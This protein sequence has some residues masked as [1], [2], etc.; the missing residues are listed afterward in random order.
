MA[1][2]LKW[3]DSGQKI[4]DALRA[5][6][7]V[8]KDAE[9]DTDVSSN[10]GAD[11]ANA[12]GDHA[13]AV[14]LG[15]DRAGTDPANGADHAAVYRPAIG[16]ISQPSAAVN[17]LVADG[18]LKG[19]PRPRGRAPCAKNGVPKIWNDQLGKWEDDDI[20][21]KI[22][23]ASMIPSASTPEETRE[24]PKKPRG[25]PPIGSNKIPQV[26]NA[27]LGIYVD[28]KLEAGSSLKKQRKK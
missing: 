26:W 3:P 10:A 12:N 7:D 13:S 22:L 6:L 14:E 20:A 27:E 24:S 23:E 5:L 17:E 2:R 25:R 15:A 18:D 16:D 8:V 1:R 19:I 4:Q 9:D 28:D 21:S 11:P